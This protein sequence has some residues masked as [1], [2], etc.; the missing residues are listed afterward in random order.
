M[1]DVTASGSRKRPGA[2]TGRWSF[3]LGL[4]A[5]LAAV[6]GALVASREIVS[7]FVGFQFFALSLPLAI[8]GLV[9]GWVGLLR[10]RGGRN[11]SARRRALAGSILSV[12]TLSAVGGLALPS[13]PFPVINDI[14]TDLADPPKFV[15]CTE[16]PPNRGRDMSYPPAFAQEQRK[17]Y[18][19]LAGQVLP[20]EPVFAVERAVAALQSIPG[21]TIVEVDPEAGRIEATSMTRVFRFVDDIVVRVRP[22]AAG[23]RIDMRSKSRDGKGDLGANAARIESFMLALR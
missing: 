23:S 17:G 22:D 8:A 4:A 11:P 12:L 13:A 21:T 9:L 10:S 18:P 6:A 1:A 15:K 16:L 7:A 20:V 14:T 5:P 19:N 3:L 2:N